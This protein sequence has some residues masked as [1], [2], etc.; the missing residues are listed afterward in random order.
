MFELQGI[1]CSSVAGNVRCPCVTAV[2]RMGLISSECPSRRCRS[3]SRV[4]V[5]DSCCTIMRLCQ[6]IWISFLRIA[7]SVKSHGFCVADFQSR[8][9]HLSRFTG[10][11][12]DL[13]ATKHTIFWAAWL[14]KVPLCFAVSEDFQQGLLNAGP[15]PSIVSIWLYWP[16]Q[17]VLCK[18]TTSPR[19]L[20]KGRRTWAT[21][22]T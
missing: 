1:W 5:P 13:Q 2:K 4:T 15:I 6:H 18:W 10:C 9:A 12:G 22:F 16:S 3:V 14:I 21:L 20:Q 19:S 17:M 7:H 8:P 11:H